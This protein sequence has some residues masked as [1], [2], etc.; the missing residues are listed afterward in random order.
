MQ[1]QRLE[2]EFKNTYKYM[3]LL[4]LAGC[5]TLG[6]GLQD[7]AKDH[8]VS[9]GHITNR[10]DFTKHQKTELKQLMKFLDTGIDP[11][12]VPCCVVSIL[13]P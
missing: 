12:S 9:Y 7:G 1:P 11:Q 4:F 10:L 8:T 5:E 3:F 13:R 6:R 2:A